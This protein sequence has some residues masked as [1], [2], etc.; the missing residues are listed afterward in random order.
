MASFEETIRILLQEELGKLDARLKRIEER[1]DKT[2]ATDVYLSP[3][4]A[5]RIAGVTPAMI[6]GLVQAGRLG[7]YRAGR[8]MRVKASELEAYMAGRDV[9]TPS[10][11]D[12]DNRAISILSRRAGR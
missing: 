1:V 8:E 3:V 6:R 2:Q 12:I 5:G 10:D 4:D 11:D 7:R 9:D